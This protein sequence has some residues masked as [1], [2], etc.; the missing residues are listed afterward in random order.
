MNASGAIAGVYVVFSGISSIVHGYLLSPNG[1]I[2]TIDHPNAAGDSEITA[3]NNGGA[4]AGFYDVPALLAR[5]QRCP[6]HAESEVHR[7]QWI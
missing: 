6:L 2:S 1:G 5:W 7:H 3:V 4:L